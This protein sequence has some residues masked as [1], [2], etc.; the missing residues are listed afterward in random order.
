[1]EYFCVCCSLRYL[2]CCY[3]KCLCVF[4]DIFIIKEV[5]MKFWIIF[6]IVLLVLVVIFVV[7]NWMV[8]M[9]MIMFLLIYIEFQVLLGVVMLG[10]VV[11]LMVF[12][13]FYILVLQISVML[14]S[15]CLIKQLEVQCVLVDQVEYLCFN[16]LC[17]YLKIELE[18]L[19]CC[20]IE[21]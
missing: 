12:F 11:V 8:F 4:V 5:D 20:Q 17:G 15:C 3:D 2:Y 13:L 7:V 10:V 16:D 18:Q 6:F 1:M 9:V 19:Q 14:E 21:Q